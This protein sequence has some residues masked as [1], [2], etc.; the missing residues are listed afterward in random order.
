V[1][2]APILV[3]D[4]KQDCKIRQPELDFNT[5]EPQ[6]VYIYEVYVKQRWLSKENHSGWR[7]V[8]RTQGWRFWILLINYALRSGKDSRTL[9]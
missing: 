9:T 8:T 1:Q 7:N 6:T 5:P 4:V 3:D 2:A